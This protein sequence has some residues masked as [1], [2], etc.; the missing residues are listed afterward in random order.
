MQSNNSQTQE[1]QPPLRAMLEID[2]DGQIKIF[3]VAQT[4]EEA[5][6]ISDR[7]LLAWKAQD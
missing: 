4:D 1:S 5:R 7:L 6:E 2:A 3:P